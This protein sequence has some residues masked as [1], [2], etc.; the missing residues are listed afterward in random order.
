MRQEREP[1]PLD[2][3]WPVDH[4]Y[5]TS[6]ADQWSVLLARPTERYN[7]LLGERRASGMPD[8][9]LDNHPTDFVALRSYLSLPDPAALDRRR[10][11]PAPP[12]PPRPARAAS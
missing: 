9:L 12:R 10:P 5:A 8:E 2:M 3:P 1:G 11:A 7:E 4:S 6:A